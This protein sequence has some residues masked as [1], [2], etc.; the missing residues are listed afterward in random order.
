MY[1]NFLICSFQISPSPAMK[2]CLVEVVSI[3]ENMPCAEI[4][5]KV[6]TPYDNVKIFYGDSTGPLSEKKCGMPAAV[7]FYVRIWTLSLIHI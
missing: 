4:P 6:P 1:H 2:I 5:P 3:G 7:E